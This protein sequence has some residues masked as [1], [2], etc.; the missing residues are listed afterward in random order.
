MCYQIT[1]NYSACGCVYYLHAVNRCLLF[2]R[3][4]HGILKRTILVGYACS[5]HASSHFADENAEGDARD[6]SDDED[7]ASVFSDISA[8]STNLTFPDDTKQEA[9]DR[10]FQELLNE[11]SLRHLWP[12][13]ARISQHKDQ[14]T[15]NIARYLSRFSRDLRA[16]ATTRLHKE[17]AGFVRI[18]RLN[19][20]D[21]I[22]ECHIN[23]LTHVDDWTFVTTAKEAPLNGIIEDE[24]IEDLDTDEKNIIYENVQHFIF[25]G[26]PFQSFILALRFTLTIEFKNTGKDLQYIIQLAFLGHVHVSRLDIGSAY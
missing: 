23:E 22:V 11:F 2:G 15:K 17:A 9:T 18:A 10:L 5:S 12:Q 6:S 26:A 16:D 19:I 3:P 4:G 8:P 21:R 25:E 14:A 1:E 20:A 13:I 24:E 7:R